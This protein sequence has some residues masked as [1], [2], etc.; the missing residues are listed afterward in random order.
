MK[1]PVNRHWRWLTVF[2]PL[3]LACAIL[4]SPLSQSALAADVPKDK[5][6]DA[7]GALVPLTLDLPKA[8]FVG[9]PPSDL[10]TNSYTEP[11]DPSK[12]RPAM[13]VP[14]GLK[15]LAPGSKLTC[16]ATNVTAE[17]L[18]KLTD[19]DK[20][21]YD[22]SVIFLRRGTQYV[23]MDLGSPQELFAIVIWHAHNV[24]KVYHDVI[25]QVADDPDFKQSVRTLFNNDQDNTSGLGIG[26]DREYFETREGRLIDAKGIKARYIRFYSRGSTNGAL[27]EYTEI[28][29]YGR[30]GK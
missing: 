23:Q 19:D 12:P 20:D 17:T 2:L 28:E 3:G 14:R 29:V 13:M 11:Y 22:Q 16:S 4:H 18:A 24:L 25:V 27:N 8:A 9:T 5:G 21:A 15:N 30:P 1:T 26:T 7:T 10:Q 6:A